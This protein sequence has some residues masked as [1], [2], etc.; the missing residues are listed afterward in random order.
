[1]QV[2]AAVVL[3]EEQMAQVEEE[4]VDFY[5]EASMLLQELIILLL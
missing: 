2:A 1:L 4:L 3:R 5:L